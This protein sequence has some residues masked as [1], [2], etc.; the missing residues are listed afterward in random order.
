MRFQC[1]PP[2]RVLFSGPVYSSVSR[3]PDLALFH[4]RWPSRTW[5][6]SR[7]GVSAVQGKVWPST[8]GERSRDPA[9]LDEVVHGTA[10]RRRTSKGSRS[11][12]SMSRA[13][14]C[15]WPRFAAVKHL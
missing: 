4:H 15:R 8:T 14:M 5:T 13:A 10:E 1:V 2:P 7:S 12:A 3:W 11:A 9:A 6:Q